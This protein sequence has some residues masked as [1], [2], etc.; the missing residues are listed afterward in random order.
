M[1]KLLVVGILGAMAAAGGLFFNITLNAPA[2][3]EEDN[4]ETASLVEQVSTELTGVPVIYE[5]KIGGYIVL[6]VSSTV[7][8]S[9]LADMKVDLRPYLSDA[10]LSAAFD[11]AASGMREV[12]A[13]NIKEFTQRVKQNAS[14]AL[15]DGAVKSVSLEQFN[16]VPESQIRGNRFKAD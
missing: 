10:A 4:V 15:G 14:D 1:L 6:R 3:T 11:F 8:R 16:F 9:V 5:G 2:H 7:D 12:T 13:A